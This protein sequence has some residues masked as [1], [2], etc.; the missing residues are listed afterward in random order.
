MDVLAIE[1]ALAAYQQAPLG[2]LEGT[3]AVIPMTGVITQKAMDAWWYG[4]TAVERMAQA[5]RLFQADPNVSAIVF[6]V[7]SPGGEVYGVQEFADEIAAAVARGTKPVVAV[8]DPV[9]ASAAY[10]L[11]SACE[12]IYMLPSGQAGSV[13]CYTMHENLEKYLERL[14]VAITFIQHGEHKTEGNPYQA[15]SDAARADLQRSVDFY[16]GLFDK[17]V[18][19]GRKKSVADVLET[20]GQGRMFNAPDAKRIG[21]VD[22]IGSIE[23]V[24]AKL[25]PKR[26]RSALAAGAASAVPKAA[27]VAAE[28]DEDI[29]DPDEDGA[30]PDGYELGEDERCHLSTKAA[31]APAPVANDADRIAVSLAVLGE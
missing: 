7:D 23:A 8:C 21:M 30:C 3:V 16:G 19:A 20:F 31:A 6:H 12:E 17:A 10:W 5:F 14:G 26:G 18:A 22:K 11:A 4:G 1:A 9:M 29:V 27:S 28:D 25:N 13:G 2:R 15:L 24:V